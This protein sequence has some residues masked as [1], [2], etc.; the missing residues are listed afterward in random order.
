[1]RS[2]VDRV[3]LVVGGNGGVGAATAAAFATA[4][5]TVAVTYRRRWPRR[6]RNGGA[7]GRTGRPRIRRLSKPTFADTASLKTLRGE[8]EQHFGRIDILVHASGFTK[9]VPHAD[10]D[11]LDDAF[12]DRMFAVKLAGAVRHDARTD[13]ASEGKRRRA[14]SVHF[15]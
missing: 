8:L 5:A 12:I 2:V 6:R 1:M 11:A 7:Q 9:A 14:S 13:A 4:G 15:L 3:V 10:L